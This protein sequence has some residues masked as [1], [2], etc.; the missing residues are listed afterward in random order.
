ML[1]YMKGCKDWDHDHFQLLK[2]YN[3][4]KTCPS[5]FPGAQ[6]ASL[7]PELLQEALEVSRCS[8]SIQSPQRQMANAF[9]VQSLA[10]LLVVA[11]ALSGV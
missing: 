11:Q 8:S 3:Y 5:R 2:I 7:H 4:L 1:F 9:V 6:S 10:M